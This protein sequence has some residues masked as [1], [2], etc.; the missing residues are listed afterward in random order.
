MDAPR[1]F[2]SHASEDKQRFVLAFA[3]ALRAGGLDVW[4]DQ[5]E[6]LPG[7][8][9]VKR[10]FTEGIDDAV[11]VVV[12]LSTNSIDKRWVQEELDAAVVKRIND[13]SR[14]IPVVLD[15]LVPEQ[16]PAPI[17]HLL[18]V[19]VAD[20]AVIDEPA[21][22]VVEAV[23]GVHDKPAV[24]SPPAYVNPDEH[25]VAGLSRS[26]SLVLKAAGDEAVRDFGEM[27]QT[28]EFLS[29]LEI[30]GITEAAG[31]ESLEVL[32]HDGYLALHRT[33]GSG[34]E[35]MSS[36][37]LASAGFEQ[38]LGT[39]VDGYDDIANEIGRAIVNSGDQGTDAELAD[40]TGHPRL[41]VLHLL[42]RLDAG[43]LLTLSQSMGIETHYMG[44]SP[45][46]KRMLS[47]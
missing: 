13:D 19:P 9:I 21:R 1:V 23:F 29:G 42:R 26:D 15:G 10:I 33:S 44:V 45:K 37:Q 18:W 40:A 28:A 20:A 31:L 4:V 3:T 5:W 32:D 12:V 22:A 41:I 2:L 46:L 36:F 39:Y 11:A 16:I 6:M 30:L 47:E 17:R 8:S 14:L 24:G 34:I 27:F 25:Q 7:D 43:G 38:Y 35:G